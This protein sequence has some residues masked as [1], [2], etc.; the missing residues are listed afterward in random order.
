MEASWHYTRATKERGGAC[1]DEGP[2]PHNGLSP[3]DPIH[4]DRSLDA[5]LDFILS[6]ERFD[7]PAER[8]F[9]MEGARIQP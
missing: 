5:I 3:I 7:M 4:V 1:I 6:V 9:F 8:H 2:L